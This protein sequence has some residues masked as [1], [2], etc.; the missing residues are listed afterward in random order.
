[1]W[2]R[3]EMDAEQAMFALFVCQ[4]CANITLRR[5]LR[6]HSLA[7]V[8]RASCFKHSKVVPF[9]ITELRC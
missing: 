9:S 4:D 8:T 5:N 3:K 7:G 2:Y 1:M 6:L